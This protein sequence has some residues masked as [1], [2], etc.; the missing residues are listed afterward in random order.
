MGGILKT[1]LSWILTA[2]VI[3]FSVLGAVFAAVSVLTPWVAGKIAG[4]IS[5]GGLTTV[6]SSIPAGGWFFLDMFRIDVGLPLVIAAFVAR[7]LIR[8]MPIIG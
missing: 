1:F 4:F 8:R 7:F 2:G 3:K 5:P 6:F